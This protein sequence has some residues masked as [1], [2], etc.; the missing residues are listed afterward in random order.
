MTA[1]GKCLWFFYRWFVKIKTLKCE[2]FLL[3]HCWIMICTCL[4][5]SSGKCYT[6]CG[7]K[8]RYIISSSRLKFLS[9]WH[10][11]INLAIRKIAS[12]LKPQK[13]IRQGGDCFT[14]RTLTTF[15]SYEISFKIGEEFKEVSKGMDNRSCQVK[16]QHTLCFLWSLPQ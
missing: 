2:C 15:R 13:V 12:M 5:H 14:I 3:A 8:K 4:C 7:S 10:V 9:F 16:L 11:G 6:C 1:L